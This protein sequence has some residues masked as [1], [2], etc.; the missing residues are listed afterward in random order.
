MGGK[1]TLEGAARSR[2]VG[3]DRNGACSGNKERSLHEEKG[4][5]LCCPVRGQPLPT[6]GYSVLVM[7]P[8]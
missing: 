1:V 6:R 8:R 4:L 7:W 5:T 3:K 2:V